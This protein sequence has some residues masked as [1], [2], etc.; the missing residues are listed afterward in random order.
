MTDAIKEVIID[1]KLLGEKEARGRFI[2]AFLS[3]FD[4]LADITRVNGGRN[5]LKWPFIANNDADFAGIISSSDDT[6]LA[7]KTISILQ[8]VLTFQKIDLEEA[9]RLMRNNI[10]DQLKAMNAKS[11]FILGTQEIDALQK[12]S[13]TVQ[14]CK[15]GELNKAGLFILSDT[16]LPVITAESLSAA[17]QF[18]NVEVVHPNEL[19]LDNT[20]SSY[21]P[22]IYKPQRLLITGNEALHGEAEATSLRS[23]F[24]GSSQGTALQSVIGIV[25]KFLHSDDGLHPTSYAQGNSAPM[26]ARVFH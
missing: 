21:F 9:N 22:L 23:V 14:A 15:H 1:G 26:S 24:V 25:E 5:D 8:R 7:A 13:Q 3:S 6:K 2:E 4:F 19:G 11:G 12:I 16:A 17:F 20:D 18:R 10:C